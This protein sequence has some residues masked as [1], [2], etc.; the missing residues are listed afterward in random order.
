MSRRLFVIPV[1]LLTSG[2]IVRLLPDGAN[3]DSSFT[4]VAL[5]TYNFDKRNCFAHTE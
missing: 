5:P 1:P 4:F 2:D 3:R